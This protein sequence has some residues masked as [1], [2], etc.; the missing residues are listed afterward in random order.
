MKS[1]FSRVKT[2]VRKHKTL[3][4][5]GVLVVVLVGIGAAFAF[6][7]GGNEQQTVAVTRG[8]IVE[9]VSVTGSTVPVQ[10]VA[11]GFGNSGTI[12]HVY[13]DVGK[14]VYRGQLLAD[15][16]TADLYAQLKQAQAS[17]DTQI[18]KLEG[19]KAG[20]RPEDLETSRAALEKA[21]Q[22]LANMYSGIT[23][24]S[25]DSYSKA[26]D[27]VRTQLDGFFTNADSSSPKLAYQTSNPQAQIDAETKRF[28]VTGLLSAWQ[29][30]LTVAQDPDSFDALL[31]DGVSYLSSV[32]E[33][34]NKVSLTLDSSVAL[35]STT[36][37]SYKANVAVGISAVNTASK[38][39][40]TIAQTIASQ[41]LA[42]A[43]LQAQLNL[44]IAGSSAQDIQAQEAQV[45]SAEAS[46]ESA[47]AKLVNSQITSPI[48]GVITQFD[49]KV[50]QL[51]SPGTP[52]ISVISGSNFEVHAGI[53]ET[54][55]GKLAIGN[56]V[57]MTIDAFPGETFVGTVFYINPA[58]SVTQGVVD[59]RVKISFDKPD[60]R[61]KSGLTSNLDIETRTAENVLTLPQYAILQNDE[62]TFV[63]VMEGKVTKDIPVT[64]GLQDQKGMVE[65][66]TGV[67]EGQEVVTIGLK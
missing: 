43:Q 54:D 38:N 13:S 56:K 11:L 47:R 29:P 33:L 57:N 52:L 8:S 42:V 48:A 21:R 62:G 41:K 26:N 25:L 49:A 66:K 51:A 59:Y 55:I 37:A 14:T 31:R 15:L 39:L 16:S 63:Q 61:M 23:D 40:N 45:K 34:L 17:L 4:V 20:S 5:V 19:L 22:D 53:P 3:T 44:K 65:V 9:T 2:T 46:V 12:S 1:L 36:L 50:G 24:T 10:S 35:T 7:G 67:T 18:A 30:K 58:E 27:A 60:P 6:G 64:L 28:L 32:R